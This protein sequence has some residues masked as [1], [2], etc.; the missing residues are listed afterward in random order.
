[1]S[2]CRCHAGC[3]GLI[4]AIDILLVNPRLFGE[5]SFVDVKLLLELCNCLKW[6]PAKRTQIL[7]LAL[8][9]E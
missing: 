3:G 2:A 4:P 5:R 8:D 6:F 1:M 7:Q 9:C